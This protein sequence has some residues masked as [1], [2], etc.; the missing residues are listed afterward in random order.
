M[1]SYVI[2][3][4]MSPY[5]SGRLP[6]PAP[7]QTEAELLEERDALLAELQAQ[8]QQ[9]GLLAAVRT[10]PGPPTPTKAESLEQARDYA[11]KNRVPLSTALTILANTNRKKR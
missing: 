11:A 1:P 9:R 6:W 8:K 10:S 5:T 4:D 2:E 7:E 3:G